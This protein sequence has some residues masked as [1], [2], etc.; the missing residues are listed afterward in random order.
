MSR[1]QRT[2]L[3]LILCLFLAG[4]FV[5]M[6]TP[7]ARALDEVVDNYTSTARVNV[8]YEVVQNST[9]DVMQLNYTVGPPTLNAPMDIW[10]T[11]GFTEVDPGADH[12]KN[13]NG[14]SIWFD[15]V[16]RDEGDRIYKDFG[17][18]FFDTD[19]EYHFRVYH[20]SARTSNP[21][22]A[23]MM[24]SEVTNDVY[25]ARNTDL[26]DLIYYWYRYS[27]TEASY[28]IRIMSSD[29]GVLSDSGEIFSKNGVFDL[30]KWYYVTMTRVGDNTT[31]WYYN[32]ALKTSLDFMMT[33]TDA[34]VS[35]LRYFHPLNSEERATGDRALDLKLNFVRNVTDGGSQYAPS[36]YFTT[37]NFLNAT[38]YNATVGLFNSTLSGGTINLEVSP[39]GVTWTDLGLLSTGFWAEDLRSQGLKDAILRFN[40]TRGGAQTTPRLFQTRIVHQGPGGA[41]TPTPAGFS[42]VQ[43]LA[44][45]LLLLGLMI[46]SVMRR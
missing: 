8:T 32:D 9:Y 27:A 2:F 16:D 31:A 11:G 33:V 41:P 15:D 30:D 20:D 14:T 45:I 38:S 5:V 46:G 24:F 21:R 4:F 13:I 44:V 42:Y 10:T 43:A 3:F 25:N 28:G 19:F 26:A 34:G 40:F 35:G 23:Y 18:G 17:A 39:D 29:E 12:L 36:G 7:Q 6:V 37:T 22:A 1:G